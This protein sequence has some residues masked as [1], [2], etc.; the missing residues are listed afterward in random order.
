MTVYIFHGTY[1]VHNLE[2]LCDKWYKREDI[3][4]IKIIVKHMCK[5]KP[6]VGISK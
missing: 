5:V 3:Y 1:W 2:S 6:P 4:S